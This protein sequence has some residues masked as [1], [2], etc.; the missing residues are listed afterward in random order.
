[1]KSILASILGLC[2]I[3]ASSAQAA[4]TETLRASPLAKIASDKNGDRSVLSV[5]VTE[6][7]GARGIRFE[8]KPA[9]PATQGSVK[10]YNLRQVGSEGG[11]VL[12]QESSYDVIILQGEVDNEHGVGELSVKFLANAIW[13][14]YVECP[15]LVKRI[16]GKW[17]LF[18]ATTGKAVSELFV[19]THSMGVTTV[20]GI[21]NDPQW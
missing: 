1:M 13:S 3:L 4:D 11:V 15:V 12:L 8:S 7:G 2:L 19:E 14:T 17:K 6:N 10:T 21:C 5:L 20:R 18:N 9:D 16:E